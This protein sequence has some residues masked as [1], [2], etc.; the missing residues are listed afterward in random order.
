MT[1]TQPTDRLDAAVRDY[2]EAVFREVMRVAAQVR[3]GDPGDLADEVAAEVLEQPESIMA[4]YPDP[5]RYARE[6]TRH[7]GISLDRRD[8]VQRGEG[9]RL[10]TGADG[11]LRPGRTGVAGD[12]PV[13]EGGSS[14]FSLL[15]D[16]HGGFDD[17][18]VDQLVA[19]E[20]LRLAL[21]GLTRQ[22]ATELLL[23]DG[24]GY[25][26]KEVAALFGQCRETVSRRLSHARRQVRQ[27]LVPAAVTEG[28][29]G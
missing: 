12:A 1:H 25:E 15:A 17:A 29:R 13:G 5:V 27:Q 14:L 23:V 3:R 24:L 21:E 18:T 22:Q 28:D 26:V 11:Q 2:V 7:A 9:A 8:R 4:R 6:R 10:F 19:A 16:P 20:R